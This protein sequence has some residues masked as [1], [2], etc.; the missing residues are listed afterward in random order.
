MRI[1]GAFSGSSRAG[2]RLATVENADLTAGTYQRSWN[3][4]SVSNGVYFVRLQAGEVTLTRTLLK[5]Q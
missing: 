2:R 4:G 3:L 1:V 5:V